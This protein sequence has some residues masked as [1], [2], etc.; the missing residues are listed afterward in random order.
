MES[1]PPAAGAGAGTDGWQMLLRSPIKPLDPALQKPSRPPMSPIPATEQRPVEA[2]RSAEVVAAAGRAPAA[3][4][5]VIACWP[6]TAVVPDAPTAAWAIAGDASR[7]APVTAMMTP[8][9]ARV[10]RTTLAARRTTVAM[11]GS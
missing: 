8:D 7:A 1:M 2:V 11:A 10:L 9:T 6:V 4:W 5:A 3:C